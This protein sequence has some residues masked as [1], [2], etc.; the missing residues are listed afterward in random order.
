VLLILSLLWGCSGGSTSSTSS[1][2]STAPTPPSA[3]ARSGLTAD[4]G[5]V[6]VEERFGV[7][8]HAVD[9]LF[10]VD[11]S[12]S[13]AP[14]QQALA[15][16]FPQFLDALD[17][18]FLDYHV[19]LTSTDIEPDSRCGGLDMAL[20]GRL[21]EVDGYRWLDADTPGAHDLFAKMALLGT[22]GSGCEKG[23]GASH[24]AIVERSDGYN[25]GFRRQLAPLHTVFVSDEEDQTDDDSPPVVTLAEYASWAA[26]LP[27][28]SAIHTITCTEVVEAA[29]G[30]PSCPGE[31]YLGTRYHH[32]REHVGGVGGSILE[33][34]PWLQI[35]EAVQVD[36]DDVFVLAQV[37]DEASLAVEVHRPDGSIEGLP[38]TYDAARQA[39]VVTGTA[40]AE[41]EEVVVTYVAA[42]GST[43]P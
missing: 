35:A 24:K 1:T 38:F 20:V 15:E 6:E 2:S 19:G 21:A 23:L 7:V 3:T 42:A 43:G 5:H 30:L 22:D 39:V 16:G 18:A 36:Q 37:P 17:G 27:A 8:A 34:Y 31:A 32:L 29:T 4:T 11:N 9:V 28:T 12:C 40:L 14:H 26:S 41:D 13:M 10:V 25:E 33:P